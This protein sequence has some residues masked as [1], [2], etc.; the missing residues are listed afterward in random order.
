MKKWFRIAATVLLLLSLT[1]TVGGCVWLRTPPPGTDTADI[2]WKLGAALLPCVAAI[3]L[4]W[5]LSFYGCMRYFL[6]DR[7]KWNI[8]LTVFMSVLTLALILFFLIVFVTPFCR[9]LND[10]VRGILF[11]P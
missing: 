10:L 2:G 6:V 11:L 1:G 5:E 9:P 3:L 8:P 7:Q 4:V